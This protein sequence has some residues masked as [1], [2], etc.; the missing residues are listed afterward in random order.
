VLTNIQTAV[1]KTI[2]IQLVQSLGQEYFCGPNFVPGRKCDPI[3]FFIKKIDIPVSVSQ[4]YEAIQARTNEA[5]AIN[6]L[7][8]ALSKAGQNYV[9]LR[10]G[11]LGKIN[12]WVI[13]QG[14]DVNIT[15]P[16]AGTVNPSASTTTTTTT[17]P[18]T[19]TTTTT[20]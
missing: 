3:T 20:R 2:A 13:P 16:P 6:V 10:L 14:T 1:R 15:G 9:L 12:F 7:N 18:S 17:A 8:S 19:T 5:K 11:E 4:A